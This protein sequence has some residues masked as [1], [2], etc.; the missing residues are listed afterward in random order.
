MH[1]VILQLDWRIQNNLS[2]SFTKKFA[3]E[4]FN[5]FG[6]R[7]LK[8]I[9]KSQFRCKNSDDRMKLKKELYPK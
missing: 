1:I 3:L 8:N 7:S 4:E 9:T 6:G 2:Q 5:I